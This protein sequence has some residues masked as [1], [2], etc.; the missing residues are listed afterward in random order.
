MEVCKCEISFHGNKYRKPALT[1]SP[2]SQNFCCST[3]HRLRL[4]M[5]LISR[6]AGLMFFKMYVHSSKNYYLQFWDFL[7]P[8]CYIMEKSYKYS[9]NGIQ[10]LVIIFLMKEKFK[11]YSAISQKPWCAWSLSSQQ[12]GWAVSQMFILHGSRVSATK[13]NWINPVGLT[14]NSVLVRCRITNLTDPVITHDKV[15]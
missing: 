10:Q 3:E 12:R 15:Q 14:K 8:F 11:C 13:K 4:F 7:P 9:H 6:Q 5:S 2:Y 1:V